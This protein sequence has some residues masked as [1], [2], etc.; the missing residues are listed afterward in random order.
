MRA[1]PVLLVLGLLALAALPVASADAVRLTIVGRDTGC[2]AGRVA[3]FAVTQGDLSQAAPGAVLNITFQNLGTQPHEVKALRLQD[4]DAA[5]KA[6]NEQLAFATSDE[7]VAPGNAS[8]FQAAVPADATG[9]YLFCGVEGH[10]QLGMWLAQ[11]FP[12]SNGTAPG[13]T[14]AKPTP[15]PPALPL[16]ALPLAAVLLAVLVLR[17]RP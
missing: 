13:T 3:C 7:D 2:P 4:A 9:L 15:L 8:T 6:S 16:A 1:P 11:A 17:R 14:G 12:A 5:H 10:E